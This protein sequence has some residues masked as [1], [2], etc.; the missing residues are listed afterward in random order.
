MPMTAE[1]AYALLCEQIDIIRE[2]VVSSIPEEQAKEIKQEIGILYAYIDDV[3][4]AINW[5]EHEL[6][7]R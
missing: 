5:F 2:L 3:T 6:G 1:E 7:R 4:N